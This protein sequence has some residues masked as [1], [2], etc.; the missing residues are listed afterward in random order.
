VER[1]RPAANRRATRRPQPC[2]RRP[3]PG[4]SLRPS[5]LR[6]REHRGLRPFG[7]RQDLPA[8]DPRH[9]RARLGHPGLHR[10][11]RARV[12]RPGSPAWRRRHRARPRLRSRPE[13]ARPKPP[14]PARRSL[15]RT[16]RGRRGRPLRVRL[17][18]A[19][20][21]GA[22]AG[23]RRGPPGVRRGF[24]ARASRCRR[25]HSS[26]LACR[27]HPAPLG[28]RQPGPDVQ[29]A[30]QRRPGSSHRRL[31]HARTARR[32]GGAGPLPARRGALD[33]D[34]T[35]GPKADARHRRARTPLRGRD[36]PPVRREPRPA[37]PQVRRFARLRDSE[38]WRPLELG[39]GGRRG[40]QPGPCFLRRPAAR[41][42]G[43][44][45]ARFSPQPAAAELPRDRASRG[46]PPRRRRRPALAR[47]EGATLAG[48]A[49]ARRA[50]HGAPAT[51]T[52]RLT[53]KWPGCSTTVFTVYPSITWNACTSSSTRLQASAPGA[54]VGPGS[55]ALARE[56]CSR[57]SSSA[58]S[59]TR[60]V[61]G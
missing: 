21:V 19:R 35:Q 51:A 57:W 14:A 27:S 28:Q 11:P 47:G 53:R 18:R 4:R 23:R 37:H 60:S 61:R 49:D 56:G 40:H 26:R 59:G 8:F 5:S 52:R 12:R 55:P 54:A 42:G 7:R 6:E 3:G 32:D 36:H 46:V 1:T 13:R 24:R 31:R 9:G 39:A 43:Q 16:R 30:H 34:Q 2:D 22:R 44:T 41:R 45:R 20:R 38:S 17:R 50:F 48:G 15:A 29:R 25:A 58:I 33:P 10:R